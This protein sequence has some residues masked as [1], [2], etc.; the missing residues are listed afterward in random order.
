MKTYHEI[1]LSLKRFENNRV[2]ELREI[3]SLY[4]F[5]DQTKLRLLTN[6]NL[7]P[8][9]LLVYLH[10]KFSSNMIY[11]LES[12]TKLVIDYLEKEFKHD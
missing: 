10:L 9:R 3:I 4:I 5:N 6:K 2:P 1:Y 11:N 7:Q 12:L 8:E